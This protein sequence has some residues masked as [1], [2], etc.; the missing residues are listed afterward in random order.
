M[1]K[2]FITIAYLLFALLSKAQIL[3]QATSPFYYRYYCSRL[4]TGNCL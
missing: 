1:K 2:N 3:T 4:F